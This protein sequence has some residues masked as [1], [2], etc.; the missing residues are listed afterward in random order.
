MSAP[1]LPAPP[2]NREITLVTKIIQRTAQRKIQWHRQQ[3]AFIAVTPNGMQFDF[4]L[5][6]PFPG[7]QTWVTFTV[8]DQGQE[9][10]KVQRV[11][12]SLVPSLGQ[13]T[14]G[15]LYQLVD[16]LFAVVVNAAEDNI[17]QALRKLDQI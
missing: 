13:R 4:I 16:R 5:S 3:S 6:A 2:G 9:I 11:A 10:F 15:P 14:S 17:D 12:N 8:R 1:G 7:N